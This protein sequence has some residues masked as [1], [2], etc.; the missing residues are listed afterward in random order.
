MV[1]QLLEFA[2]VL[3][4]SLTL[5]KLRKVLLVYVPVFPKTGVMFPLFTCSPKPLGDPPF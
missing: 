3:L 1:L 4:T 5:R 2:D